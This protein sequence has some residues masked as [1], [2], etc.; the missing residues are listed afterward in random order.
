MPSRFYYRVDN[1]KLKNLM[2]VFSHFILSLLGVL[3]ACLL[4]FAHT[5]AQNTEIELANQYYS[6]NE[7]D[8][9]AELYEKVVRN[10]AYIPQVHRYYFE[11]LVKLKDYKAANRYLKKILKDDPRSPMYNIDYARLLK[12]T[13]TDTTQYASYLNNYL[14]S[15]AADGN[16]VRYAAMQLIDQNMHSFAEQAYREGRSRGGYE[17]FYEMAELYYVWGKM[18]AMIEEYMNLLLQDE[19]QQEYIQNVLQDR[20][21]DDDEFEL[22]EKIIF[23]YLQK[24]QGQTVYSEMLVWFYL[25]RKE[26]AK[27]VLQAKALD[28]R[29]KLDGISLLNIGQ[30]AME[31]ASYAEA[32]NVFEYLVERY[33]GKPVY[34]ISRNLLI[35]SKEL[36][37]KNTFPIDLQKIRSL[38]NDYANIIGEMG[39]RNNTADAVRS[40]ALLFAFY[41]GQQD[42]AIYQLNRM[43]NTPGLSRQYVSQAKIDLADIY[44]LK[45]EHWEATLLY[46]QVEKAEKNQPLGQEAKL[47]N[48]RLNYYK[49]DFELARAHLDILKM[50]TSR[51]IAN[52]AMELSLL[53]QDNLD[54]DTTDV[55]LKNFAAIELIVFQGRLEEAIGAYDK[56]LKELSAHSLTDDILWRKANLMLRMGRYEQAITSL[57]RIVDDFGFDIL[58]DDANFL[59]AR[60]YDEYLKNPSSAMDYYR[61]Q[62][63]KFPGSVFNVQ[64]RKRF[65]ELRGDKLN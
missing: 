33:P 16:L 27:A 25:Q 38:A 59:I 52:D 6:N 43:V 60:I 3:M 18:G 56:L 8:K 12:L 48:A 41:L 17:Y 2:R 28:R 1:S 24:Y 54:L 39:I 47:R 64:A 4:P 23:Q 9:A 50:A 36:L 44:L 45:G 26:F 37:V 21:Q 55:H 14:K 42:S 22:M 63:V 57:Q 19:A 46:S 34:A 13:E 11:S 40:Q 35:K 30:L 51:E 7:F 31:N 29:K 61:D 58:A 32:V 20:L 49:G 62:L 15:I 65:R 53:I 5:Q 10:P